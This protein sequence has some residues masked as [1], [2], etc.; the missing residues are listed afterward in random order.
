MPLG[1][2]NTPIASRLSLIA[3]LVAFAAL[4]ASGAACSSSSASPATPGDASTPSSDAGS[5]PVVTGPVTGGMGK[6]FTAAP[7]D[8]ASFGYVEEE[9]F[10]EGNATAY[11]WTSPPGEDGAWSVK[12]TTSAHYKT[13]ILVRRPTDASKFNGTVMVEWLNVTG[14]ADADPDF[15][16][17]HVELLRSGYA[18]VGVSAQAAG[19]IGGGLS[20]GVGAEPLVKEDPARYGSLKHPGDD[21][22]YDMYTQAAAI[23]RHPGAV[24]PLGGLKVARMIGD[25]ESQSAIRMVTYVN[26]IQPMTHAFDGFFIHSRF[27]GGALINGFADAGALAIVAG[28]SPAHIRSDVAVPVFQFETETDVPGLASGLAG[29]GYAVARQPDGAE[30]RTWEVA[31][32][33][34]ADEYLLDYE[35]GGLG[36]SLLG[37]GG[38]GD[39]GPADPALALG[40]SAANSGPEHWVEDAAL[41]SLETWM[42]GGA[43]P[44][45]GTPFVLGDA[46]AVTIAQDMYGNA[47]GGVRTAAV[48]VPIATYSGQA[49]PGSSLVCS[50][51]GKTTPFSAAQLATLYSSHDDYVM[52]VQAATA[53]AQ[54]AGFILAAD[55][56]LIAQEAQAAPIPQ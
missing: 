29:Q 2:L 22:A 30:L 54:Q 34:H 11:D 47:L 32:T 56:P 55:A 44:A 48:D 35:A 8:L 27:G 53:K 1:A 33:A 43:P 45:T 31:G 5:G 23:V 7:L 40:C 37:D 16:Y 19:V 20:L 50:F 51:F 46:G 6:P 12:P 9:Y 39:G 26:A 4:V 36:A 18:Y 52:K 49:D 38:A 13:R 3:S 10:L 42:T 15:G 17:G 25:G 21:Y 41:S 28:P 24:D 14:G